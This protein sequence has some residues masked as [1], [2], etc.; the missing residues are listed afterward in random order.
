MWQSVLQGTLKMEA[1]DS[2]ET[3]LDAQRH[4]PEDRYGILFSTYF[5]HLYTTAYYSYHSWKKSYNTA[6]VISF[7]LGPDGLGS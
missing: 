1:E 7:I 5:R 4:I 3:L 6:D 2:S